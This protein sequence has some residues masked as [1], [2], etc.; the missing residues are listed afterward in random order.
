MLQPEAVLPSLNAR[1]WAANDEL[2][3]ADVP[4]VLK[5]RRY[6][7]RVCLRYHGQ[8]NFVRGC[9]NLQR[10]ASGSFQIDLAESGASAGRS[11][12]EIFADGV[13]GKASMLNAWFVVGTT[14]RFDRGV[15]L[16]LRTG[17]VPNAASGA[18]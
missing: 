13:R 3:N 18:V 16:R 1:L 9:E 4:P 11:V 17:S 2:R 10:N 14:I 8:A 6:R 15:C 12:A 7:R 5:T